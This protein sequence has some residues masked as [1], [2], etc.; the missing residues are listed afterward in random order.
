MSA[1]DFLKRKREEFMAGRQARLVQQISNTKDNNKKL[2]EEL[3]IKTE[4]SNERQKQA[5][6]QAKIKSTVPESKLKQAL[7]MGAK[8]VAQNLKANQDK[9]K[10]NNPFTKKSSGS[11][12]FLPKTENPKIKRDTSRTIK[13]VIQE[14][15]PKKVEAVKKK[16]IFER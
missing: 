1:I 7:V 3:K 6:L 15:R 5:D 9:A 12:A 11:S 8:K 4:F 10:S 13:V 16:G 14:P 2:E